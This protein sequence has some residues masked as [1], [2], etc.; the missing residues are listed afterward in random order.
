MG[1]TSLVPVLA[2]Q[3]PNHRQS[4]VSKTELMNK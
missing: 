3:M 4:A 1:I 2:A